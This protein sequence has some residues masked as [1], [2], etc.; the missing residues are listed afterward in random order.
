MTYLRRRGYSEEIATEVL[1]ALETQGLVDDRAFATAFARDRV[2]LAP[3]GYRM[4]ERELRSRGVAREIIDDVLRAVESE[5]PEVDV[6]ERWLERQ[7]GAAG[8]DRA[9]ACRR[10]QGKGF[11]R[12]TIARVTRGHTSWTR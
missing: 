12:E 1:A 8:R 7:R 10:L 4:I 11:R 6:A 9:E 3:R 2:R 5:F